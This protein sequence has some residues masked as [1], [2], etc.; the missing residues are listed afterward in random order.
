VELTATQRVGM[1]RYRFSGTDTG[2]VILDLSHR[3]VLLDHQLKVVS[4][5]EVRGHRISTAWAREQHVY[6]VARFSRPALE[7][8][9]GEEGKK[10]A[11][12]FLPGEELLVKVGISF[13]DEAGAEKNLEAELPDWD[14]ER[15]RREATEAW[16]QQLSRVLL[17]DESEEN[18]T[19]FYTAQYH[20]SLVPNCF[21]DMDGRYRG[22]DGKIHQNPSGQTR[23][24]VFSLWDTYRAAHPWYT[25]TEQA[26]TRDFI[27]TL[28][29]QHEE[30]GK[31]PMWEL[32]G[33]YTGCM[34]GYHAVPVI[35]DAY[36][37]GLRDYDT[38]LAL[39]AMVATA[40][41]DELGKRAYAR[42]G[43]VPAEEEAESVSKTLEYAYDDCC[44]G[45]M[46]GEMGE[47]ALAHEFM[48][49]AQSWQNLLDPETRFMRARYNQ[50]WET[51]FD[52][53]QV[54]FA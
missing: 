45:R 37:K 32:A 5:T 22:M 20:A 51:P 6:F 44:I 24:S 29:Q 10:A 25:L 21:T 15:V 13:V 14:A 49:R 42:L 53:T 33:N 11:L 28:L 40:R 54:T 27:R 31:L 35:Y 18:K 36:A 2:Q 30:G 52:P 26:R 12:R 48:G 50:R 8:R 34:I 4:E 9:V 3:D 43:F 7:V 41:A 19:I 38:A 16:N 46:A 47:E 23:Y 1:H 39:Q 17:E